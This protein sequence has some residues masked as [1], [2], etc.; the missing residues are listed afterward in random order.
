MAEALI[1][2]GMLISQSRRV[3]TILHNMKNASSQLDALKQKTR[4]VGM[5]LEHFQTAYDAYVEI[6]K[7]DWQ[8][9]TSSPSDKHNVSSLANE[10]I[11]AFSKAMHEAQKVSYLVISCDSNFLYRLYAQW[12]VAIHQSLIEKTN[13]EMAFVMLEVNTFTNV[14]TLTTLTQK[15]VALEGQGAKVPKKLR[16]RQ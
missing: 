13:S 12:K 11:Q 6:T 14:M 3:T 15:I 7:R 10:L 16:R 8:Q 5:Y 4:R 2:I 1:G 9:S